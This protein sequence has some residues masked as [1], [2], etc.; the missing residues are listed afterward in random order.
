MDS[1]AA[2]ASEERQALIMRSAADRGVVPAIIEKDFWVCWVLMRLFTDPFLGPILAF[3]GGTSLSKAY[4]LIQR[5]SEDIDLILDWRVIDAEM[6]QQHRSKTQRDRFSK[7]M[8]QR[9]ASYIQTVLLGRIDSAL[10]G[11]NG[12]TVRIADDD[13]HSVL[14]A[15]PTVFANA[16]LRPEIRLEI[17][18]L[19]QWL[20]SSKKT[21]RSY[22]AEDLPQLFQVPSCE[23][24]TI[25]AE[26]TFWEKV[27][28]L[29]ACAHR[30]TALPPRYAR[31]Y[32]DVQQMVIGGVR[33]DDLNLLADV[34]AFKQRFYASSWANYESAQP[35]TLKLLPSPS[36][37]GALEEDYAAMQEMF[38][39]Q[40][41]SFP[42]LV[43]GLRALENHLNA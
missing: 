18:P 27:T 26:R 22:I 38:F 16:Y 33:M 2:I 20:P 36:A 25:E 23:V 17:G 21:I 14:V 15:Y 8:N 6:E 41:P 42:E 12:I 35:G 4:G 34:V 19:A 30:P 24:L 31:H 11:I 5:F 40:P 37:L 9:A 39:G 1:I 13:P 3:K 28:I 43:N 29:H 32:Y 7:Q 10:S